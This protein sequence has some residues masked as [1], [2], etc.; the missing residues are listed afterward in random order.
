MSI[1]TRL[2][3]KAGADYSFGRETL[4]G[5]S[6]KAWQG[7]NF[8]RWTKKKQTRTSHVRP[9]GFMKWDWITLSVLEIVGKETLQPANTAGNSWM[10]KDSVVH[11][12]LGIRRASLLWVTSS[13]TDEQ[14]E[15][16]NMILKVSNTTVVA[17]D[18]LRDAHQDVSRRSQAVIPDT[19]WRNARQGVAVPLVFGPSRTPVTSSGTSS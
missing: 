3:N 10:A 16:L 12:V 6:A 11:Y 17:H 7:R 14:G 4:L 8:M 13:T 5:K 2:A 9:F 15:T 19:Q 18:E 1:Y